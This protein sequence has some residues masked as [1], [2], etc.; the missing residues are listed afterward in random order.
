MK[1]NNNIEGWTDIELQKDFIQNDESKNNE[2]ENA[3]DDINLV[4]KDEIKEIKDAD[5]KDFEVI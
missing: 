3:Q 5:L 4:I 2:Q 1:H